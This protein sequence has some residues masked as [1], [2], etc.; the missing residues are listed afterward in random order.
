[1]QFVLFSVDYFAAEQPVPVA[2]TPSCCSSSPLLFT[3]PLCCYYCELFCE[4]FVN[5][6][7]E[8]FF[9]LNLFHSSSFKAGE[10]DKSAVTDCTKLPSDQ[11][12]LD[13]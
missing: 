2:P 4:F 12:L 10:E 13:F 7:C 11:E 9:A 6:Y 5:Y 3:L 8:S 1:M